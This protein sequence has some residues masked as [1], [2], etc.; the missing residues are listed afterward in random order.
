MHSHIQIEPKLHSQLPVVTW[1]ENHP[2]RGDNL[3]SIRYNWNRIPLLRR[4]R[5]LPPRGKIQ[6]Q[7]LIFSQ[8]HQIKKWRNVTRIMFLLPTYTTH[9][10]GG[11]TDGHNGGRICSNHGFGILNHSK[12]NTGQLPPMNTYII[13]PVTS[14]LH[15]SPIFSY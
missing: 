12:K 2:L 8:K 9:L 5:P 11:I 1:R 10:C 14:L 7:N 13:L 3:P 6:R 4:T 15:P